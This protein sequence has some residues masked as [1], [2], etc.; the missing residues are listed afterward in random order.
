MAGNLRVYIIPYT[1]GFDTRI[2][3]I[4]VSVRVSDVSKVSIRAYHA[5]M[6][7]SIVLSN[8]LGLLKLSTSYRGTVQKRH[9]EE[10]VTR[11]QNPKRLLERWFQL[12][13]SPVKPTRISLLF[14][15]CS[16]E[17]QWAVSGGM[18]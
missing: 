12:S 16:A 3:R 4:H 17:E 18:V 8:V 14:S 15:G 7:S 9:W 6:L 5:T 1:S 11:W 2:R 13:S 10:V